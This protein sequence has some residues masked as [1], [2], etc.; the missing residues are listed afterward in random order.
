MFVPNVNM[1]CSDMGKENLANQHACQAVAAE[2]KIEFKPAPG[3][4]ANY[5]PKC[6]LKISTTTISWNPALKG[7][8]N[9]DAKP[10]CKGDG[11]HTFECGISP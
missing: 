10:I 2:M 9:K 6:Y 8:R 3:P 1:F 4:E 5:P 11:K 7:S